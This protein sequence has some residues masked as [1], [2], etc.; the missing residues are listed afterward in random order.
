MFAEA[1]PT[2]SFA[3]RV[4]DVMV[5]AARAGWTPDRL[6]AAP[7][8]AV[9]ASIAEAWRAYQRVLAL[10]GAIDYAELLLRATA[11]AAQQQPEGWRCISVEGYLGLDEQQL[12]LLQAIR[13]PGSRLLAADDPDTAT[14]RFRGASQ[15]AA[16]GFA[17]RHADAAPLVVLQGCYRFGEA[18]EQV[19][20]SLAAPLPMARLPATAV[21]VQRQQRGVGHNCS[22]TT[23]DVLGYPDD[24][25]QA[26][27]VAGIVRRFATTGLPQGAAPRWRD[28]AV[29]VRSAGQLAAFEQ[30]LRTAGVPTSRAAADTA[31]MRL[32]DAPVVAH[33]ATGLRLAAGFAGMPV[34]QPP[35]SAVADLLVSGMAGCDPMAARRLMQRLRRD[36]VAEA[37][38]CG[39]A[40]RGSHELLL[41]AL[42]DGGPLAELPPQR[43]PAVPAL[44]AL[45]LRINRAAELIADG[46]DVAAVLWV[47]WSDEPAGPGRWARR[48]Q[49]AALAGGPGAISAD[50]DLD[51]A[52]AL[53]AA[54]RR[55][56]ARGGAQQVL[57]FL[58]ALPGMPWPG[59]RL[60]A[61]SSR[62]NVVTLLT[63]HRAK[64]RQWPLVVVAGVQ[65]GVWPSDAGG[66]GLLGEELL[67]DP[68][69]TAVGV[70]EAHVADERRLFLL[71]AT[72]ASEH[73]VI[74][75]VA[76][77]DHD[78]AGPQPS[79]FISD[80]GLQLRSVPKV[81][82]PRL[83]QLSVVVDL[84]A[85]A[86][87]GGDLAAAAV[88]RLAQLVGDRDFPW[89]DPD[90][91]WATAERSVAGTPL[92]APG[93]PVE[94]T[95]TGLTELAA[96]PW[97]WVVTRTLHAGT[98]DT[99]AAGIGRVVHR[100]H[101]A[102]ANAEIEREFGAAQEIVDEVW[103]VL[104]F[105]AQWQS[106][107]RRAEVQEA[108]LRLL[109]WQVAN[110][111]RISFA[112]RAFAVDLALADGERV[113]LRGK[114]D[115][116]ID[117]GPDGLAVLDVKTAKTPPTRAE[118][119]RHVQLAG[120]QAA[121][122][123]G[124]LA[125]SAA[126]AGAGLLMASVAESANSSEPKV[127][128]QPPLD[129]RDAE[130]G[131]WFTDLLSGAAARIRS[132]HFPAVESAG[133]RTCPI[134]ALCPAKSPGQQVRG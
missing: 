133:C 2:R 25:A 69:A 120:Y 8:P 85:G 77:G 83:S 34:P 134:T 42:R 126:P 99:L 89:A 119:Q 46:G 128:W 7:G 18:V 58:S 130:Q 92:V 122:A 35:A 127:L 103:R 14:D 97:R 50:R 53:F 115:L 96:C 22:D 72:R 63:A 95:V 38:R 117:E 68:T 47:L 113:R 129:L 132:E 87:A 32:V 62:G 84:R 56:V 91:W 86:A 43:F 39:R 16:S 40:P 106:H 19:R 4:R 21:R 81:G 51:A 80:T 5:G 45:H 37:T 67:S 116:G 24:F 121:V 23:V 26:A 78:P 36:E 15:D 100:V 55:S 60:A 107:R 11:I 93:E 79:R 48:L 49:R 10:A 88:P 59:E 28:A 41:E 101:E 54:A 29:I 125:D 33:L 12:A 70:R 114:V 124:G 1:V 3:E 112:E 31:G 74:T 82:G 73:L 118:V 105:D 108:L 30:A 57:D 123:T 71:A 111:D 131:G 65:E 109:S 98:T 110:A 17:D 9:W 94:L 44:L 27:G 76:A 64:G 61:T 66:M 20:T 75:A 52:L 104:P 6:A 102:W 90:S 13:P